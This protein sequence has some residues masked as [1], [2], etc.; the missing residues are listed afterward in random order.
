MPSGYR[1]PDRE[2]IKEESIER[3]L[4][5]YFTYP[6]GDI[7]EDEWEVRS[8]KSVLRATYPSVYDFIL[9]PNRSW[10]RCKKS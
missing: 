3:T 9:Q 5:N 2:A 4:F 8:I 10:I 7:T 1:H 6:K